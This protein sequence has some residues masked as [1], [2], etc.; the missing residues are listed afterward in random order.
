MGIRIHRDIGYFLS[1]NKMK[2]VLVK[3]YETILNRLSSDIEQKKFFELLDV[4]IQKEGAICENADK[5]NRF[6]DTDI[7]SAVYARNLKKEFEKKTIQLSDLIK[8][9]YFYDTFKGIVF[10]N[11]QMAKASRYDDLIDYYDNRKQTS[12]IKSINC[13]I[14]PISSY[15]YQGGLEQ[16]DIYPKLIVGNSYMESSHIAYNINRLIY[17]N[18]YNLNDGVK[19]AKLLTKDGYFKPTIDNLVYYIVKATG[20]L[21]EDITIA[22]FESAL[23]PSIITSW[24]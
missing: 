10:S 12:S 13:P 2:S 19:V 9:I 16:Y 7:E 14:Y 22:Q 18:K 6:Y 5:T 1:K 20:I 4:F 15:V 8:N 17:N 24:N 23:E 21:K 3:N 11:E